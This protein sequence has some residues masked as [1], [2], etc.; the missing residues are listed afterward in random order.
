MQDI[1]EVSSRIVK[2]LKAGGK[3]LIIGNGGSAEM[4]SHMAAEFINKMELDRD[5]LPAIALTD[6]ANI[7]SI[8]ND[9]D[10]KWIFQRQIRALGKRG[11]ILIIFTTSYPKG[12]GPSGHSANLYHAESQAHLQDIDVIL[13]PQM[14]K[15]TAEIQEE[16][17]KWLHDVAR[18][19]EKEFV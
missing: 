19:V 7:T 11:D 17:L 2:C 10:F 16:Q 15:T 6:I 8:A 13:A 12:V 3:L 1:Q 18:E 9:T 5:P 14:S 4:A